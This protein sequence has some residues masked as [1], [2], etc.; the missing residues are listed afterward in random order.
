MLY[1]EKD[2]EPAALIQAKRDGLKDYDEMTTDV[3]DKIKE[4]LAAEQGYLCAYCMRRLDLD[5]M[6]I[7][8]YQAQ[9]PDEGDYDSAL[10]I[11]YRNMLGVCPGNKGNATR[12]RDLTCDQHRGNEKLTVNPLLTHSVAL[13]K[14]Q[15]NGIIY[16]DNEDINDDLQKKLNLNC[17]SAYL[18]A[19]RKAALDGLK[20]KIYKDYGAKTAPQSY[21]QKLYSALSQMTNGEFSVYLGILLAYLEKRGATPSHI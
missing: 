4:H 13:I 6:Q 16:S 17:E 10:T 12:F 20:R 2:P 5:T 7:E 3:K 19:N 18:P 14:Y 15:K 1:I 9:H 8:H 21:Y 11:D